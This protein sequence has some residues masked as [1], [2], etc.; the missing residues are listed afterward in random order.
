MARQ[1]E[2]LERPSRSA[3]KRASTALQELGEELARVKPADRQKLNLPPD[4][5]EALEMLDRITDR[6][7]RRRQKQFIGKIMRGVDAEAIQ[8][9][10]ATLK[11]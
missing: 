9:S 10:L 8:N 5:S 6:E 4:L 11:N 3:K 1:P 7:A 2:E